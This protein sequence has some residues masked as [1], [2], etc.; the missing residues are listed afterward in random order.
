V[1][2]RASGWIRHRPDRA[3]SLLALG[4]GLGVG[5]AVGG[6][7]FYLARLI[8]ARE[9]IEPRPAREELEER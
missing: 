1:S 6:V 5:L 9:P 8:A 4:A 2:E 3:Q 7:V